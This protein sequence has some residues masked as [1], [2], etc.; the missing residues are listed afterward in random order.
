MPVIEQIDFQKNSAERVRLTVLK[1]S[2]IYK[3]TASLKNLYFYPHPSLPLKLDKKK[4][5]QAFYNL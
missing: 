2:F 4:I 5:P 3:K 1:A